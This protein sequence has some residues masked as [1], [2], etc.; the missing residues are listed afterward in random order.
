MKK[1]LPLLSSLTPSLVCSIPATAQI[2][3][4]EIYFDTDVGS[5]YQY[6]F[7][8]VQN[9]SGS[10]LDVTDYTLEVPVYGTV[11][12]PSVTLGA[13]QF[14]LFAPVS[15]GD[16]I[17][18]AYNRYQPSSFTPYQLNNILDFQY[19]STDP[20]ANSGTFEVRDDANTLLDSVTVGV[21]SVTSGNSL[22]RDPSTND[23]VESSLSGGTPGG[24]NES[25]TYYGD[26]S[27]T[28]LIGTASDLSSS[29]D[30]YAASGT[31]TFITNSTA[32]NL[33]VESSTTFNVD[34][35]STNVPVTLTVSES[36][37]NDG[38]IEIKNECSLV[39]TSSTANS[40]SGTFIYSRQGETNPS[41]FA[42][43]SSSTED[44][45]IISS[46]ADD[47]NLYDV[48]TLDVSEQNWFYDWSSTSPQNG[49][50]TSYSFSSGNLISGADG[51]YDQ[52][53]GYFL[54]G[55]SNSIIFSGSSFNNGSINRSVSINSTGGSGDD[56]WNLI[57]NPYPS[58]IDANSFYTANSSVIS[59]ALYFWNP[60]SVSETSTSGYEVWTASGYAGSVYGADPTLSNLSGRYIVASQGFMVEA[61]ANGNVSF[62]NS[63]RVS[64]NNTD[65][66]SGGNTYTDGFP[67]I[68]VKLQSD[69]FTGQVM[70]GFSPDVTDDRDLATDARLLPTEK[71]NLVSA[72]APE[73]Y[74]MINNEAYLIQM[75]PSE[76]SGDKIIPL[77]FNVVE[78]GAQII[79]TDSLAFFDEDL[80]V[81]LEDAY[82]N[83]EVAL[84]EGVALYAFQSPKGRV[85]DRFFLRFHN[86]SQN[87]TTGVSELATQ[88]Q[89][90]LYQASGSL[91]VDASAT[92]ANVTE[93]EII[94]MTGKVLYRTTASN[95][96]LEISNYAWN[97]T[98]GMFL[99][100]V[101]M[102]NGQ[103]LVKKD[104]IE[105]KAF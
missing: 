78:A 35:A 22:I 39:Q 92:A 76:F 46:L 95:K 81:W 100:V 84:H 103:K 83:K 77:G 42:I 32:R 8:E 3:I 10:S 105:I 102:D 89:I 90:K 64:G 61:T 23:W 44:A 31:H 62:T 6:E 58:A 73:S 63:M 26:G 82:L 21:V 67:R 20:V 96:R 14:L 47:A 98:P 41:L 37:D 57:G 93:L 101:N 85:D 4:N 59:G 53:R 12:F 72:S 71:L 18:S 24:R 74:S 56:D 15:F 65:F 5:N 50:G 104:C 11:N 17:N 99:V 94:D 60:G 38:T 49:D 43:W 91:W 70:I 13:D 55:T 30:L 27:N 68:W 9:T 16:F 52:A 36:V 34:E 29:I 97:Q 40:G 2:T 86:K 51:L 80:E 79:S 45:N 48:F 1:F 33:I 88:D 69:D 87:G 7:V 54:P 66:R 25:V 19:S 75:L 28:Q